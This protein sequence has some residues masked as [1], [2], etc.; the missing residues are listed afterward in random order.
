MKKLMLLASVLLFLPYAAAIA[1]MDSMSEDDLSYHRGQVG[2]TID[3]QTRLTN[4]YVALTDSN[5]FTITG[6][7]TATST[8][9]LTLRNFSIHGTSSSTSNMVVD[10]LDIDIGSTGSENYLLVGMPAVQGTVDIQ[11]VAVGNAPNS[12][13]SLSA[14]AW[15]NINYAQTNLT[16]APH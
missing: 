1:R 2:I 7:L 5:G 14:V 10:G 16:I 3:F 15:G 12:G 6:S 8:G 9:S 13:G 4:S 11:S